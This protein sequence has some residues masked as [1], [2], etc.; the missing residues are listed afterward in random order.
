MVW[1]KKNSSIR[2]QNWSELLQ[3]SLQSLWF[4][5]QIANK[6][7]S[8]SHSYK[9]TVH[10]LV[11]LCNWFCIFVCCFFHYQ[12]L[13]QCTDALS[14]YI[15]YL[16]L[17]TCLGHSGLYSIEYLLMRGEMKILMYRSMM[18]VVFVRIVLRTK[19]LKM[20]ARKIL[21]SNWGKMY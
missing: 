14:K 16:L 9:Q 12:V 15:I 4:I 2:G 11:H 3:V 18:T 19:I 7:L 5:F 8:I 17:S 13:R 20:I 21:H 1:M 10:G 6:I